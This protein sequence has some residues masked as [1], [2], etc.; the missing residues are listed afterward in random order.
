MHWHASPR[1]AVG[2]LIHAATMDTARLGARRNLIMPG[3]AATVAEQ[4]EALRKVAGDHAVKRIRREPDPTVQRIVAGWPRCFD[5]RRAREAG[6]EAEGSFEEIVRIHIEDE[7]SG[8][9]VA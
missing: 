9:F 1:A 5:A 8:R 3:V 4:I 2:F 6:F 7:Q